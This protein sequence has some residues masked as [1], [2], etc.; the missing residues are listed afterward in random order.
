MGQGQIKIND[1]IIYNKGTDNRH[2]FGTGFAVHKNYESCAHKFNP[3]S[4]RICAIRLK[5]NV[6]GIC[7][8]NIHAPT[9]NSDKVV[10]TRLIIRYS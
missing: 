7:L 8:I 10:W 2:F 5:T 3:I 1:Y 4:E 9:E 6:I